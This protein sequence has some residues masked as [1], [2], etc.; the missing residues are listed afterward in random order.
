VTRTEWPEWEA[1]RETGPELLST[2]HRHGE[3]RGGSTRQKL[4][5]PSLF[6]VG[7]DS[8]RAGG[9]ARQAALGGL[10]PARQIVAAVQ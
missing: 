1:E 4:S 5:G 8:R 3:R 10:L 9:R 2:E 6:A 7:T